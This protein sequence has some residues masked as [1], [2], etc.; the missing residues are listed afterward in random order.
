[1]QFRP[2]YPKELEGIVPEAQVEGIFFGQPI[3][4]KINVETKATSQSRSDKERENYIL[5]SSERREPTLASDAKSL[6]TYNEPAI[7]SW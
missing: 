3:L 5:M 4:K 2:L 1:M 7:F 6:E